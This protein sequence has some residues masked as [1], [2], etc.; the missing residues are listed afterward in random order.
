MKYQMNGIGRSPLLAASILLCGLF[1]AGCDDHI[2]VIRDPNIPVAK[3]STWAWKPAPPPKDEDRRPVVSRDVISRGE[4][5]ARGPRP[6]NE[7]VRERIRTTIEQTLS[8]KGLRQLTAPQ[9]P[10]F[11]VDYHLA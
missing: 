8:S 9:P 1:A 3:S 6:K 4:T 11:L 7:T 2:D 10:A 5:V